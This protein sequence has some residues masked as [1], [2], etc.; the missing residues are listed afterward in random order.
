MV[1]LNLIQCSIGPKGKPIPQCSFSTQS[2]IPVTLT[3]EQFTQ[4]SCVTKQTNVEVLTEK[5]KKITYQQVS[6][7]FTCTSPPGYHQTIGR[8][9]YACQLDGMQAAFPFPLPLS[10]PACRGKRRPGQQRMDDTALSNRS[11]HAHTH[12]H[13]HSVVNVLTTNTR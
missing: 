2:A 8:P 7:K 6:V 3:V 5:K 11:P 12:T 13:A 4:H 10:L 1:L 9:H